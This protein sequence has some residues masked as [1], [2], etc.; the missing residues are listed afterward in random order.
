[1]AHAARDTKKIT[2]TLP[3]ALIRRLQKQIPARQRSEFVAEALE[4]H[5]ALAEQL[6]ALEESAGTWTEADHPEL[7][8]PDDVERWLAQLRGSW[9]ERLTQLQIGG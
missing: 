6:T 2:V 8:T 9:P 7:R 5:L 3:A 4:E 1:M